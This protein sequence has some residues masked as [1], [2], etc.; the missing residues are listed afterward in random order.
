MDLKICAPDIYEGDAVGNHC[1]GIARMGRR[2]GYTVKIY[3]KNF[4]SCSEN[5]NPVEDLFKE[6]NEFDILLLSYSIFDE[7]LDRIISLEC[8]KICYFHGITTPSLL[9]KY[10]P[11]TAK[12]CNLAMEQINLFNRFDVVICNSKSTSLELVNMVAEKPVIVIPP[13]FSDMPIFKDSSYHEMQKER[14]NFLMVGRCVPH[15]NIEFAIEILAEVNKYFNEA[16]LTIAGST[17]NF[18]YLK[19]LIN[20]A[21]KLGVLNNIDFTG[22]I[23]SQGLSSLYG[24]TSALLVTSRHEGFCV[25][26]LE[27]IKFGKPV[28][29]L[30]GTAAQE[31]DIEGNVL[32]AT[33][34]PKE[35]ARKIASCMGGNRKTQDLDRLKR[36][37]MANKLLSL[38]DDVHWKAALHRV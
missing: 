23:H 4:D 1:L 33:D 16:T 11:D 29:M 18:L 32:S 31:L 9:E 20:K 24:S 14:V 10:E 12:L 27:S 26:A 3:A 13:V 38:A 34:L 22:A 35:W 30:S 25:P 7:Y 2:L 36:K 37:K 19:F 6:I 5:I 15:K 28:F 21:R 17:P 8:K